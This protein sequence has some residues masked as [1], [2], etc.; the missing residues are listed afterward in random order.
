M[1]CVLE[2][3]QSEETFFFSLVLD[4]LFGSGGAC[5]KYFLP[6]G[7][8]K[9]HLLGSISKMQSCTL[10]SHMFFFSKRGNLCYVGLEAVDA[11]SWERNSLHFFPRWL[12]LTTSSRAL[13]WTWRRTRT[14]GWTSKTT[15]MSP[16]SS[17]GTLHYWCLSDHSIF[18]QQIST[19][20]IIHIHQK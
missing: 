20:P 14:W 15:W 19:S 16:S 17:P 7:L 5:P 3:L 6:G 2:F 10:F 11:K 18:L 4:L 12:R 1:I 9:N 13:S 8:R